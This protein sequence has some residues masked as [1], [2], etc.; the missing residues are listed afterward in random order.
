MQAI[1][2]WEI[3][4][5]RILQYRPGSVSDY[6]GYSIVVTLVVIVHNCTYIIERLY[7]SSQNLLLGL[8][9]LSVFNLSVIHND[10]FSVPGN[11]FQPLI[12]THKC[13]HNF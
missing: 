6:T 9:C 2:I 3:Y 13:L 7:I 4:V 1:R 10:K 11:I 12:Y 5:K 8:R